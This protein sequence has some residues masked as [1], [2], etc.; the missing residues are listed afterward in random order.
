MKPILLRQL[1]DQV[2]WIKVFLTSKH[3]HRSHSAQQIIAHD[4]F[5]VSHTQN[6]KQ[7]CRVDQFTVRQPF[8]DQVSILIHIQ[9][10]QS[11]RATV[12]NLLPF[13]ENTLYCVL[14]HGII[15]IDTNR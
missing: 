3:R 13:S 4:I 8:A 11:C 1:N 15:R 14:W 2:V 10:N 9:A 12:F 5:F 7:G 6:T